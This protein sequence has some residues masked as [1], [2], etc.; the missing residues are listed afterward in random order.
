MRKILLGII[1]IIVLL[2][3]IFAIM[4][5]TPAPATSTTTTQAT[6]SI[7]YSANAS[8][9]NKQAGDAFLADNKKKSDVVTL[10]NGLQYKI[11]QA[12]AGEKP[13]PTS[14]VVVD[15]E[16]RTLDGRIFQAGN[17]QTVSVNNFIPGIKQALPLMTAGSTWVIYVPSALG[18]GEKGNDKIG[19]NETLIVR[20]HLNSVQPK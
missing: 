6:N 14:V 8:A 18:Y 11:L 16:G 2:V 13:T 9:S 12:R 7:D 10:P 5:K 17:N 1:V 19:P 15:F 20:V 4:R 3:I